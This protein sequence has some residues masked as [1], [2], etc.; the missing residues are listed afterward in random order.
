MW[1]NAGYGGDEGWF[2]KNAAGVTPFGITNTA[3]P[4]DATSQT[5]YTFTAAAVGLADPSRIIAVIEASRNAGT[6]SNSTG[7]TINGN[8]ATLVKAGISTAN[9]TVTCNIW[10]L[11]VPSGTT[12]DF[13]ITYPSTMLR[14]G[15][16][17]YSILGSDGVAPSG[18][19]TATNST[20]TGSSVAGTITVPSGGGS[21]IGCANINSLTVTPTNYTEDIDKAVAST[22]FYETGHDTS[23]SGSTTF[24]CTFSGSTSAGSGIFAA[25]NHA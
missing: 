23:G 14:C 5:A 17:V 20:S 16:S 8:A 11:A 19:A 13:V 15:L 10:Q 9:G 1:S 6:V 7:V 18:S 3:S 4:V 21:I 22:T 24:T 12:A 2:K 25:W